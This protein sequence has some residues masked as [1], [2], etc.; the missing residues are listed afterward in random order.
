VSLGSVPTLW[1]SSP[2]AGAGVA[3]IR[4]V[5]RALM[6]LLASLGLLKV[7]LAVLTV[8]VRMPPSEWLMYYAPTETLSGFTETL[9]LAAA[10]VAMFIAVPL[11][12]NRRR[13]VTLVIV[14]AALLAGGE[15][16]E[17]ATRVDMSLRTTSPALRQVL[18]LVVWNGLATLLR[19]TLPVAALIWFTRPAIKN[20][21]R[22]GATDDEAAS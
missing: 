5:S 7:A 14:A 21:L 12:Q 20:V 4:R 18:L 8:G 11:L 17:F 15:V 16:M 6:F 9:Q 19:L 3:A 1:Y 13:W 10:V 2:A 22:S